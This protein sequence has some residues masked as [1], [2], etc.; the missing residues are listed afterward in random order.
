MALSSENPNQNA[1]GGLVAS[2]P[3][4][5]AKGWRGEGVLFGRSR[6]LKR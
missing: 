2:L 3:C 6:L 4:P 5:E 1:R